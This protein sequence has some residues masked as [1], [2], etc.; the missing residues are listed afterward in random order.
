MLAV[1]TC[2]DSLKSR[3]QV[4]GAGSSQNLTCEPHNLPILVAQQDTTAISLHAYT[5]RQPVT[6][7]SAGKAT[8]M[9]QEVPGQQ[10]A[11][12]RNVMPGCWHGSFKHRLVGIYMSQVMVLR[13]C[14]YLPAVLLVHGACSGGRATCSKTSKPTRNPCAARGNTKAPVFGRST[15][16]ASASAFSAPLPTCAIP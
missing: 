4:H 1:H 16:C 11:H 6:S 13:S 14:K 15:S 7:A 9:M 3:V 2:L 5:R 8:C 12:V 10:N